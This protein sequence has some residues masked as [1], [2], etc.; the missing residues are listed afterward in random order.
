MTAEAN[1]LGDHLHANAV[2]GD[3]ENGARGR[4]PRSVAS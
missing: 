2:G 1:G 4:G 3:G